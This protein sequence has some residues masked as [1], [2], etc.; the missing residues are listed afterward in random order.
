MLNR[1]IANARRIYSNNLCCKNRYD[2]K[3]M[4]NTVDE[5]VNPDKKNLV[6]NEVKN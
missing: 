2:Q 4:W 6:P 5:I 1:A 3:A